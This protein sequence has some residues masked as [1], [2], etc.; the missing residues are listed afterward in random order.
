VTSV[1]YQ[2]TAAETVSC[3]HIHSK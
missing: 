1:T 3:A 2:I